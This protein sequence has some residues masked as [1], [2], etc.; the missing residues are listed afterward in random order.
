M[1][2]KLKTHCK[3]GHAMVEANVHRDKYGNR[4]CRKCRSSRYHEKKERRQ[5]EQQ[6]EDEKFGEGISN[7]VKLA[8][9]PAR[10]KPKRGS[11]APQL[12]P[13]PEHDAPPLEPP[14][15]NGD[16]I[17][18]DLHNCVVAQ[19]HSH[20]VMLAALREIRRLRARLAQYEDSSPQRQQGDITP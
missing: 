13:A 14:R 19:L 2:R 10:E 15:L 4:S 1:S 5:V 3:R 20:N 12:S 11:A 16:D 18:V 6:R 9:G 17:T 8:I 7:V